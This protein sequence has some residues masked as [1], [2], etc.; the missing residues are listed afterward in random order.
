MDEKLWIKALMDEGS[1]VPF[2]NGRA[3]VTG[4]M[5]LMDGRPVCCVRVGESDDLPA[6]DAALCAL[7]AQVSRLA[8]PVILLEAQGSLPGACRELSRLSGVCPLICVQSADTHPLTAV[9]CDVRIGWGDANMRASCTDIC[10][11]DEPDALETVRN[12][13]SLLPG[14][15]AEDAPLLGAQTIA[16]P[17]QGSDSLLSALHACADAGTELPLYNGP[18]GEAYLCRVNGRVCVCAAV[19]G[20]APLPGL[21]RLLRLGDA[22]SLPLIVALDGAL[23]QEPGL[24]YTLAAATTVKICVSDAAQPPL[25]DWTLAGTDKLRW[26]VAAALEVLSSKRDVLLPRKH[27]NMPL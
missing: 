3:G 7:L 20:D 14:S 23:P 8:M 9:L 10:A 6:A 25:F 15:C 17:V 18:Q 16:E 26:R 11:A 21:T 27:G 24:F 1:Y 4:G 2:V 12:L 22:F 13:F 5:G 19:N